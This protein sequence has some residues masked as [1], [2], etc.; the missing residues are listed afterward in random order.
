MTQKFNNSQTIQG[1]NVVQSSTP[2]SGGPNYTA[3]GNPL[4]GLVRTLDNFVTQQS[5][6]LD[7]KTVSRAR[8]AGAL[9]GLN[10]NF[11][12]REGESLAAEAFNSAAYETFV[13]KTITDVSTTVNEI[14]NRPDMKSNPQKLR[15]SLIEIGEG[16]G[17][18][19]PIEVMP[20]FE[21][22]FN[23]QVEGAVQNAQNNFYAEQ[24]AAS[25]ASFMEM[26]KNLMVNITNAAREGNQEAL[27]EYM[28]LYNQRLQNNAPTSD[29]GNGI[30]TPE[31]H[32]TRVSS[33]GKKVERELIIGDMMRLPDKEKPAFV[34]GLLTGG[35]LDDIMTPEEQEEFARDMVRSL[36]AQN[37]MAD[38]IKSQNDTLLVAEAKEIEKQFVLEP[39]EDNFMK[40]M[41]HPKANNPFQ[42]MQHMENRQVQSDPL[43]LNGLQEKLDRGDLE[44]QDLSFT[45]ENG[46]PN[47]DVS[48]LSPKDRRD[49]LTQLE[50][51]KTGMIDEIK[52]M[53]IYKETM[54]RL[55]ADYGTGF[56]PMGTV[57]MNKQGEQIRRQLLEYMMYE[58][59]R[60]KQGESSEFPDPL[61]KYQSLV[62]Q[63]KDP[64]DEPSIY[65]VN[66]PGEGVVTI[67]KK[68]VDNPGLIFIDIKNGIPIRKDLMDGDDLNPIVAEYLATIQ[69]DKE[70]KEA[71]KQ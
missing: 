9:A 2:F 68:Y 40:L 41:Q 71:G 11:T 53:P 6:I 22:A 27:G 57:V 59:P 69:A 29:G 13:N 14:A 39:T 67:P 55:E 15:A 50:R 60:F 26:E 36:E 58:Y 62:N 23:R 10:P 37:I 32:I 1:D 42:Y 65:R 35:R 63:R 44:Y 12:P 54:E 17:A 21:L 30:L 25:K 19:M 61:R 43:T 52:E 64:N 34:E 7:K 48:R 49:L 31:E 18:E 47:T 20:Q 56:T 5:A 46:E 4:D 45:D 70:A 38:K 3:I 51:Q 8:K 16:M 24:L 28:A 33:I 66:I